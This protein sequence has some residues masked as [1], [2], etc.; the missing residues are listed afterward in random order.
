[1]LLTLLY[2]QISDSKYGNPLPLFE[3]HLRYIARR[4]RTVHPG[5]KVSKSKLSVCLTFDDATF[6]FYALIFP[7]LKKYQLKA[8][9]AVPTAFIPHHITHTKEERLKLLSE[10]KQ[11]KLSQPSPAFCSWDELRDLSDSPLIEIASHS[12]NHRPL[13]EQMVDSEYEF[14]ASKLVLKEML[15]KSPKTFVYPFGRF[16]PSI[17]ALAKKHYPYIMRIGSALNIDWYN[18]NQMIYRVHADNL[19]YDKTPFLPFKYLNYSSR[20]ILNAM[21]GK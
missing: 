18:R 7:L 17:H 21:R 4:Y 8:V 14:Y 2:H 9:L 13:S 3:K 20:F 5:D 12:V 6:D 11:P 15:K 1:M 10:Y 16:T 19:K